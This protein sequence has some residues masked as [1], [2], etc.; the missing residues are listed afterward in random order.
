VGADFQGIASLFTS[1][2]V[3]VLL[4]LSAVGLILWFIKERPEQ[5]ANLIGKYASAYAELLEK[6]DRVMAEND[7]KVDR[8]LT[9][10]DKRRVSE[11][12]LMTSLGAARRDLNVTRHELEDTRRVMRLMIEAIEQVIPLLSGVG[13][14]ESR[15]LHATLDRAREMVNGS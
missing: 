2:G 7:K 3:G 14:G 11:D 13:N 6:F 12:T 10:N 15:R 4:L 8:L 9:E 1:G 5:K